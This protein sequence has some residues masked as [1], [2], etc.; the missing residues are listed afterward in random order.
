MIGY[1]YHD[2]DLSL[3]NISRYMLGYERMVPEVH[4]VWCETLEQERLKHNRFIRLKPRGTFKTSLYTV[5][6][7]IEL[8]MED[9][10]KNDGQ[11]DK[12]ILIASATE[13]L[14]TQILGEISSHFVS[15]PNIQEFFGYNPVRNAKYG[16][17]WLEPRHIR[18]EPNVKAIG[19]GTA[20]VSEHYDVI[21]ADDIVNSE[22]RESQAKRDKNWRWFIDMI[23]IL[24]PNGYL[25]VCG[26]RWH[27]NDVYAHLFEQNE[28][29]PE[30]RKYHVEVESAI[31]E[32]TGKSLFP[33]ILTDDDIEALKIEKGII[34]FNA[35]YMNRCI[36]TETQLFPEDRMHLYPEYGENADEFFTGHYRDYIYIDPALGQSEKSD[37]V[38]IIVG[39]AWQR[40]LYIRDV[41]MSNLTT[42]EK[43]VKI[44]SN[45]MDMYDIGRV[46]IETN[47]FQ[48]LYGKYF[49]EEDI[50]IV[51]HK[52]TKRKE[53]RIEGLEPYYSSGKIVFREDWKN[54]YKK[55]CEQLH[56]YPATDH[57]DAPD[58]LESLTRI[59]L[60]KKVGDVPSEVMS[61]MSRDNNRRNDRKFMFRGRVV[62]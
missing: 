22:D 8:L 25:F 39:R 3:Y 10:L 24:E 29:L 47:G 36:P 21:I 31:D 14:A 16:E 4:G 13:T 6:Q 40:K 37:Y 32:E 53:I 41:F 1:T 61:G 35:Q 19:S 55:F 33:S 49:T 57:D 28:L 43:A 18:K 50:P 27:F 30:H 2:I 15:N 44:T 12:R 38:V 56:L 20:I 52:N 60:K 34:E 7:S 62:A 11:F 46:H 42:P 51:E 58:A 59:A 23:S 17:L 26:T 54:V 9:W 45:F 5:S 48:S